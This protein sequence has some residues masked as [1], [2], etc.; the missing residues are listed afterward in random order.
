MIASLHGIIR[1]KELRAIVVDVGGVGYRVNAGGRL[2][3]TPEG[4]T[5]DIYTY[6]HTTDDT[7]ELFGF[8]TPD[9]LGLFR[10]LIR[11]SG[12]GP[13]SAQSILSQ[14][15]ANQV[16]QAILDG[17]P[18]L[19]M[20]TPGV[21][22]KT[23]ERI[24]LELSGTLAQKSTPAEDD[25]FDALERLGYSRREAQEAVRHVG[26]DVTDVRDR[27]RFALRALIKKP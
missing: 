27:I 20:R 11:V 16:R 26:A 6:L 18:A 10:S 5:V 4:E 17:D 24:I 14:N 13:K 22:K 2:L 15:P 12:V 23:A 9:E 21:G 7:M 1:S 3:E 19:I 8:M 25:V